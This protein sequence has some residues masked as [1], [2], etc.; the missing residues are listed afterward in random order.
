MDWPPR[1]AIPLRQT[2]SLRLKAVGEPRRWRWC[3][4][5]RRVDPRGCGGAPP[6]YADQR[7][8]Q[9]RSPRVRGSLTFRRIGQDQR[10]SIP[11]GAGEPPSPRRSRP[12]ARVDPRGCGGAAPMVIRTA[13]RSGR[14]PR[15][16][17]SRASSTVI[18]STIGSIPAGAGEP[19]RQ[20][21]RQDGPRVD[22]RGCGGAG[23]VKAGR[24]FDQGRSPRV[25]GSRH[26]EA[27]TPP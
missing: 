4:T 18:G 22:P 10:G 17:G 26:G 2:P 21:H 6:E 23:P 14:S 9:G 24:S 13:R 3:G 19:D 16:R 8:V 25:R 12:S 1:V 27:A 11:A 15:V 20:Q 7:R 5:T